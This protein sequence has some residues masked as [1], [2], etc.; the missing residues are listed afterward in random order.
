MKNQKTLR[1]KRHL[2]IGV[3]IAAYVALLIYLSSY[4][5]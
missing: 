3:I 5:D 4:L 2:V 1:F